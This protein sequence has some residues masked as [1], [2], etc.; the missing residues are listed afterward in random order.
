MKTMGIVVVAAL[1]ANVAGGSCCGDHG[2]FSVNQVGRQLR[3][4]IH[5][6]LGP[7]VYDRRVLALEEARFS[8]A[9]AECTQTV[10][11]CIR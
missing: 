7:A 4:A 5:L 11:A 10:S 2:D 9:Q 6:I 8:E 1:A 3:Q